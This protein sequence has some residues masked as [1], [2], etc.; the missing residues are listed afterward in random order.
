MRSSG[1]SMPAR[2]A[3][4]GLGAGV[5]L[6]QDLL[7]GE[8]H[9]GGGEARAVVPGHAVAEPEAVDRAAL[10]H[11]PALGEVGDRVALGVAA[12]E[13]VVDELGR[14]VG[15]PLVVIAG[16]RWPGSAEM[17]TTSV[18]PRTGASCAHAAASRPSTARAGEQEQRA[19]QPRG[20]CRCAHVVLLG[21]RN[22][23][24]L[25]YHR[26]VAPTQQRAGGRRARARRGRSGGRDE[27][28]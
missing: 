23:D 20:R 8:L 3:H 25:E 24:L 6:Q 11:G 4:R 15:A 18:P 14:G 7:E 10:V 22:R 17:A 28:R 19:G 12:Q 1:A 21:Y 26:R 5:E 13:P 27:S 9:V 16:L 2:V